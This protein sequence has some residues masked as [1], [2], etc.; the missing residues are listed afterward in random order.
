MNNLYLINGLKD[1][2]DINYLLNKEKIRLTADAFFDEE[3]KYV[4]NSR[5]LTNDILK[6]YINLDIYN[7][8]S[9]NLQGEIIDKINLL[10]SKK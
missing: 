1:N 8:L 4:D 3:L 9:N 2:F 7:K 10:I 6:T 5:L